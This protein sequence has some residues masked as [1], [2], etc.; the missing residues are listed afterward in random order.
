[1]MSDL[2]SFG[3]IYLIMT[4]VNGNCGIPSLYGRLLNKSFG[5]DILDE[6]G[7]VYVIFTTSNH[8]SLLILHIDNYGVDLTKLRL[9]NG[10]FRTMLANTDKPLI[11]TREQLTRLVLDGTYMG[12]WQN[13]QL[14]VQMEAFFAAQP[15][16]KSA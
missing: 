12:E 4:P 9:F 5:I 10:K 8:K 15:V 13:P 3:K 7:E 14:Q 16:P 2:F 11:L 1:M 6:N